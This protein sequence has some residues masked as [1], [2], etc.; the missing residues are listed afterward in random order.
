MFRNRVS[1]SFYH[2]FLF[3]K[4]HIQHTIWVL[5]ISEYKII[6]GILAVNQRESHADSIR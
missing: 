1:E 6:T 5:E 3:F 4:I 2:I